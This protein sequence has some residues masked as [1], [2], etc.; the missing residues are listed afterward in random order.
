MFKHGEALAVVLPE[1]VRKSA[2][3]SEGDEYDFLELEPGILL[4]INKKS[5]ANLAKSGIIAQLAGKL[6]PPSQSR[7]GE[8]QQKPGEERQEPGGAAEAA[9][10]DSEKLLDA[11]GYLVVESEAE[12]KDL[13]KSLEK[14][15]RDGEVF[16]ARGFDKKFYI[17][18]RQFYSS[19]SPRVA[20]AIA[21]KA[22][23]ASELAACSKLN[24]QACTAIL[25][26]MKERGEAIEKRRGVFELVK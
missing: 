18:S 2:G 14:K 6:S 12:A 13:S 10:V 5:L 7:T 26:L 15:I 4:L 19:F 22:A 9:P 8:A 24:E 23:T 17:V 25:Q 16:G 11:K 3:A 20:K 21:G 1:S